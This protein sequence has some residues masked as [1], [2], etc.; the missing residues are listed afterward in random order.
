MKEVCFLYD[1][2]FVLLNVIWTVLI[3][4]SLHAHCEHYSSVL[5]CWKDGLRLVEAGPVGIEK[6]SAIKQEDSRCMIIILCQADF[7]KQT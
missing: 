5:G 7:K 2:S 4:W 1:L 6:Y 3:Q